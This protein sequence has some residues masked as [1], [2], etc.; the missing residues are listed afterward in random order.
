VGAAHVERALRLAC[1]AGSPGRL[2][3]LPG[4]R[5]ARVTREEL[6]IESRP[7]AGTKAVSSRGKA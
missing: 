6:V 2:V 3:P 5:Q 7:L 1:S 4:G